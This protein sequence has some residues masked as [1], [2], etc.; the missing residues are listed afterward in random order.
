MH[1]NIS[2]TDFA[3]R[4]CS[5]SL[6]PNRF[7]AVN[8]ALKDLRLGAR[9]LSR[10]PGFT[11]AVVLTL[12]L[13]IG[14]TTAIFTL[15]KA[16]FLEPLPV[17]EAERLVTVFRTSAAANGTY[18]GLNHLS[19]LDFLDFRER[20]ATLEALALYQW[21]PVNLSGGVEPERAT[22]MFASAH[23]FEILGIRP[24]AGR[25]FEPGADRAGEVRPEVV[26]SHACWRRLFAGD[27]GVVG[28]PVQVNGRPFDVVGVAPPGFPGTE[29]NVSVDAWLPALLYPEIAPYR[30]LFDDRGAGLFRVI[31]RLAPGVSLAQAEAEVLAIAEQLAA[32]HPAEHERNRAR[33]LPLV[34]AAIHPRERP[35]Y[36]SY[37]WTLAVGVVVVLLVACINVGNLLLVRGAEHGRELA[38]CQALGADRRRLLRRLFGE[39][40]LLFALGGALALPFGRWSLAL[41]WS[42]RPPELSQSRLALALDRE[43][44]LFAALVTLSTMAL[45]GLPPLWRSSRPDLVASLRPAHG[46]SPVR[47]AGG[48]WGRRILLLGQL[49]LA[50]VGLLGAG[51]FLGSLERARRIDLGFNPENLAVLTVAPGDLGLAEDAARAFYQS[52][53]ERVGTLPEVKAA[54][55]SENRLLRGAV[56]RYEVYAEGSTEPLSS[57][58]GLMHR[59]NVVSPGFFATAGIPL[60]AGRDFIAADCLDCP[61]VA[62]V[63]RALAEAAWP[64]EQAVGR[65]LHTT[66]PEE[67]PIEVVGVAENARYRA[68][69]EGP[70]FFLYF[71]L[72]QRVPAGMTLHVRT[73]GRPEAILPALRRE[74][75]AL[76]PGLPVAQAGTMAEFVASALWMERASASLLGAFAFLAVALAVLGV[77]S[78]MAYVVRQR[79]HEIGIRLALGAHRTRIFWMVVGEAALFAA[80][81]T[82]LGGALTL[83]ALR[84]LVARQLHGAGGLDLPVAGIEILVLLAAALA[85]SFYPAWRAAGLPPVDPL[86]E[87]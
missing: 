27:P 20:S 4:F 23:Y 42:L 83:L 8:G 35:S 18:T 24:I 3:V 31:G 9:A 68:V 1:R 75:L 50:L 15:L 84:P 86:K 41:L 79:R 44:L 47:S 40:G 74:V 45:C 22:G 81:A 37:G 56:L 34:E 46:S 28:R 13:G 71:P 2:I 77:Y 16:L 52:L 14:C 5:K 61:P 39:F 21:M 55:L 49:T 53:L 87:Q 33:L 54:A 66:S 12:S 80:V 26:L 57:G 17:T 30:A 78:T 70:L 43:V 7:D 29:I 25:F 48:H 73:A 65:R 6:D 51:L 58:D 63:N 72:S 60:A 19:Y 69:R 82:V 64:G 11:A 76:E 38:V 10:R 62:I 59:A 85:G 32:E 36:V 67:P